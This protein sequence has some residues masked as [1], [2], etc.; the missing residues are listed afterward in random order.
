MGE[1]DTTCD[2]TLFSSVIGVK[3]AVGTH[4]ELLN[5]PAFNVEVSFSSDPP[6]HTL[7]ALHHSETGPDVRYGRP[8]AH[9]ERVRRP[10]PR[11]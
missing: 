1:D 11:V 9:P 10:G 4:V 5:H 3:F 7:R 2:R 8:D 6:D